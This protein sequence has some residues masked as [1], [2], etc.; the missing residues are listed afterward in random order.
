MSQMGLRYLLSNVHLK[1][2][3]CTIVK[4][5]F[6]SFFYHLFQAKFTVLNVGADSNIIECE[7]IGLDNNGL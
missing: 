4:Q 2:F 3:A 1:F 7:G 5:R 6:N